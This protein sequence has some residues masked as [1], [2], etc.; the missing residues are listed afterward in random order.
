[1]SERPRNR[2]G[3]GSAAPGPSGQVLRRRALNRALLQRQMLLQREKLSSAEAIE[4][5]VGMQTQTPHFMAP[6]ADTRE[7]RINAPS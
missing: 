1:L 5:L 6:D 4:R 7:V 3:A 2:G